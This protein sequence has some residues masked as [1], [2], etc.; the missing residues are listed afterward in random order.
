MPVQ[1]HAQGPMIDKPLGSMTAFPFEILL[2]K[3]PKGVE[4]GHLSFA[5][6]HSLSF[7]FLGKKKL[8][9]CWWAVKL[10]RCNAS[11]SCF[12]CIAEG[13]QRATSSMG[14]SWVWVP[15]LALD[16]GDQNLVEERGLSGCRKGLK[17]HAHYP[18]VSGLN[19]KNNNSSSLSCGLIECKNITK[20]H[21]SIKYILLSVNFARHKL[22][23]WCEAIFLMLVCVQFWWT[24][25]LCSWIL[26]RFTRGRPFLMPLAWSSQ[27]S[28]IKDSL[29]NA[30]HSAVRRFFCFQKVSLGVGSILRKI[31]FLNKILVWA[32]VAISRGLFKILLPSHYCRA[33][34]YSE[35]DTFWQFPWYTHI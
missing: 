24:V 18:G 3:K 6:M 22:L 14:G 2:E 12:G 17:T 34:K 29:M 5:W 21:P 23:F 13:L 33:K 32:R 8:E 10:L 30:L 20:Y 7:E 26:T 19:P 9:N 11:S 31:F 25:T 27:F 15:K 1:F 28:C 4:M 35:I 16:A